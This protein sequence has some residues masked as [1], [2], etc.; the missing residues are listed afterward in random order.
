MLSE[1]ATARQDNRRTHMFFS[2][3]LATPSSS[4][5]GEHEPHGI[6]CSMLGGGLQGSKTRVR[7]HWH[8]RHLP[9]LHT[10]SLPAPCT[11][12]T[13]V[14]AKHKPSHSS[15]RGINCT[16]VAASALY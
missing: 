14:A 4:Q 12:G 5:S 6:L 13:M 3:P 7:E 9:S 1:E 2:S 10:T 16:G 11:V 15:H 8:N